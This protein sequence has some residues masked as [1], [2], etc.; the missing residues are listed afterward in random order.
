MA[1]PTWNESGKYRNTTVCSPGGN[2]TASES[3]IRAQNL[4]R[5]AIQC[6]LPT[7]IEGIGQ[8]QKPAGL[9]RGA[10]CNGIG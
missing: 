9:G 5:F 1:A 7:R 3:V 6:G 2:A 4:Y 8:H 10:Y